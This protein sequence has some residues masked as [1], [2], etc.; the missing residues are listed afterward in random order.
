MFKAVAATLIIVSLTTTAIFGI[1]SV[2]FGMQSHD[3]NCLVATIQGTD[4]PEQVNPIDYLTFHL[5]IL[6]NFSLAIL[7]N[8]T[9]AFLALCL[10]IL[11]VLSG[12]LLNPPIPPRFLHI[13]F[14]QQSL[15]PALQYNLLHWLANHENS[16]SLAL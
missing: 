6:K 10:I 9:A 15:R 4:C 5:N 13:L 8:L 1:W 16:P 7:H 3:G 2:H 11:I 14:N 12:T